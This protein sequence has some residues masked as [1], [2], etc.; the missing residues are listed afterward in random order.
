ML[1]FPSLLRAKVEV[2]EFREAIG[3]SGNQARFV[4][5]VLY[6][7]VEVLDDELG[8]FL[9]SDDVSKHTFLERK[10]S[11]HLEL[12]LDVLRLVHPELANSLSYTSG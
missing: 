3:A 12:V 4:T 5:L 9:A 11:N 1:T 6:V 10:A 8:G 7:V 2:L